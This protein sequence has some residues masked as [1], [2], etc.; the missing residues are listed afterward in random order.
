ML[1]TTH[2]V[3]AIASIGTAG[4]G[5]FHMTT[6]AP[7]HH[8]AARW[9]KSN[10][11]HMCTSA[12]SQLA[13]DDEPR[14]QL[15]STSVCPPETL[16]G[17]RATP[18]VRLVKS[19]RVESSRVQYSRVKSSPV[20]LSQVR[21][22]SDSHPAC[23]LRPASALAW[24]SMDLAGITCAWPRPPPYSCGRT[25]PHAS[26]GLASSWRAAHRG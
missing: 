3:S 17:G 18:T 8:T 9:S 16:R 11:G 5:A 24:T 22:V 26:P 6:V 13:S 15:S 23:F 10:T 1:H 7:T 14:V 25:R 21:L 2:H 20:E 4:A 12:R 19:S